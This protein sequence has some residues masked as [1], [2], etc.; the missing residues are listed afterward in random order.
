[1][2]LT[3]CVQIQGECPRRNLIVVESSGG[4]GVEFRLWL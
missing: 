2:L 1:M 4:K 3:T